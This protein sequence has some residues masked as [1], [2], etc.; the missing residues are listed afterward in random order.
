MFVSFGGW[1]CMVG[2]FRPLQTSKMRFPFWNVKILP[3]CFTLSETLDS[4]QSTEQ[5]LPKR[6]TFDFWM[7]TRW[8]RTGETLPFHSPRKAFADTARSH[9]DSAPQVSQVT[10]NLHQ[11]P[12]RLP[13]KFCTSRYQVK[14]FIIGLQG[15]GVRELPGGGGGLIPSPNIPQIIGSRWESPNVESSID[16]FSIKTSLG[17]WL[18]VLYYSLNW[19]QC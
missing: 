3:I 8:G 1:E 2:Y 12:N 7:V 10:S 17:P 19:S 6:S 4:S 18:I 11:L 16:L 5:G 13:Y 15:R 9:H 14:W